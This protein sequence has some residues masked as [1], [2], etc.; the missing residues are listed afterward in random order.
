MWIRKIN[1]NSLIQF[2]YEKQKH[3][4]KF[5][6]LCKKIWKKHILHPFT[7]IKNYRN[8]SQNTYHMKG[9]I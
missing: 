5:S 2:I 3:K 4:G 1:V 9:N 7:I 6:D 8:L